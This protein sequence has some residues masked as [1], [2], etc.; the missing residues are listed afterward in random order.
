MFFVILAKDGADM[1]DR[2]IALRQQHIDYWAG[3][4][5]TVKAAGAILEGDTPVGSSFLIE[6]EDLDA[7][8]AL[9]AADPFSTLGVF[10][11]DITIETVRLA[12]GDWFQA[13]RPE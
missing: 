11:D 12:I 8:R 4:P 1:L 9:L 10:G 7:A 5:K 13:S 3:L 2:R 6:A